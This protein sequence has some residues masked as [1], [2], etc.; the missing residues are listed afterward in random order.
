MQRS[1][2]IRTILSQIQQRKQHLLLYLYSRFIL[3]YIFDLY[4]H[5]LV[6][7][8]YKYVVKMKF[9]SRSSIYSI[10]GDFYIMKTLRVINNDLLPQK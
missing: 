10:V 5:T 6:S 1:L 4:V 3:I 8:V 9:K 2:F 7:V